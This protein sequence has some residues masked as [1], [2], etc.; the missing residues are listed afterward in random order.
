[1]LER[2]C[3]SSRVSVLFG[4][5]GGRM[6][7][8]EREDRERISLIGEKVVNFTII[9]NVNIVKQ[10]WYTQLQFLQRIYDYTIIKKLFCDQLVLSFPNA[11]CFISTTVISRVSR[12]A[13]VPQTGPLV[14]IPRSLSHPAFPV[15][16]I[17]WNIIIRVDNGT[18][19]FA[20]GIDPEDLTPTLVPLF[21]WRKSVCNCGVPWTGFLWAFASW[22]AEPFP[23]L[24]RVVE[25]HEVPSAD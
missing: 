17:Q 22:A 13:C 21:F 25:A 19:S 7:G 5:E 10:W 2:L 24:A 14:C 18:V 12:W 20:L 11:K 3:L 8:K 4:G 16:I 15:H 9:N 1:M 23:G 6:G